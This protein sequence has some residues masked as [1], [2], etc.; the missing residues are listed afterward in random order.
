MAT[1]SRD[2]RCH[3]AASSSPLTRRVQRFSRPSLVAGK[4]P[5]DA[6]ETPHRPEARRHVLRFEVSADTYA[7]FREAVATLRRDAGGSL[8]DD[9]TLL[10]LARHV[11]GGPRDGGRACYQVV[12]HVCPECESGAQLGDGALVPVSPEIIAGTRASSIF[13]TWYRG[14]GAG[15]TTPITSSLC[16]EHITAPCIMGSSASRERPPP[17]S[18]SATQTVATTVV[19]KV[20]APETDTP[21]SWQ[22]C[23]GSAFERM[24]RARH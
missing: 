12:L 4:V 10:A 2:R 7:T 11:L 3:I 22:D 17:S 9:E 19:S 6:P 5:G 21:E 15:E 14:R 1:S 8:N 16:A 24:K 18:T 20:P 23:E 13:T